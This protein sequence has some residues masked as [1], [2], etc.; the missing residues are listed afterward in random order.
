MQ[1]KGQLHTPIHPIALEVAFSLPQ[2][3]DLIYSMP[4][5]FETQGTIFGGSM[6]YGLPCMH[7][8]R[9]EA[10]VPFCGSFQSDAGHQH[11]VQHSFSSSFLVV[12]P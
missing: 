10:A 9:L 6:L 2:C 1:H 7:M 8:P 3:I 11:V 4:P 12:E 5:S